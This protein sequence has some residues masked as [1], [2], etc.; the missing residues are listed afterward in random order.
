V[1]R[2]S[3]FPVVGSCFSRPAS[4]TFSQSWADWTSPG[5]KI[6]F[7]A[8]QRAFYAE[9]VNAEATRAPPPP[10]GGTAQKDGAMVGELAID[11]GRELVPKPATLRRGES[12]IL[13]MCALIYPELLKVVSLRVVFEQ[14]A[15]VFSVCLSPV[16]GLSSTCGVLRFVLPGD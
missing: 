1:F 7:R 10:H 3:F 6:E 8:V 13:M 2:L 15:T 11:V 12:Y 16:G 4:T 14:R 9:Q 5:S